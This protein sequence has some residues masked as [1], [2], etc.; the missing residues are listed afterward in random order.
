MEFGQSIHRMCLW[1]FS[2]YTFL[3]K[4]NA[5]VKKVSRQEDAKR[6]A[7]AVLSAKAS[8]VMKRWHLA[9]VISWKWGD[10]C[11]VLSAPQGH[12]CPP[13]DTPQP[14][15]MVWKGYCLLGLSS[16][17]ITP[18]HFNRIQISLIQGRCTWCYNEVLAS[19]LEQQRITTNAL[20]QKSA[21]KVHFTPFVLAGQSPVPLITSK[22]ASNLQAAWGWKMVVEIK[23]CCSHTLRLQQP[24]QTWYCGSQQKRCKNVLMYQRGAQQ[25][26]S[27]NHCHRKTS[28]PISSAISY[29]CA[30]V[31]WDVKTKLSYTLSDLNLTHSENANF[32][33]SS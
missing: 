9:G 4:R 13:T 7:K 20:P 31:T 19:V 21:G 5:M 12:L 24:G 23:L 17:C 16:T 22:D 6:Q 8:G 29:I 30:A 26:E 14:E 33:S 27:E 28:S 2:W 11:W 25:R 10:I 32:I 3:Q 18:G 15:A 1:M